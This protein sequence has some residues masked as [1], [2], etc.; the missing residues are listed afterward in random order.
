MSATFIYPTVK[1]VTSGFIGNR[2]HHG[3]DFAEPGYHEIKAVAA[4]KVSRSYLST[5]YGEVVFIVHSIYGT[6]YESVYAHMRTGSRRVRVGDKVKQGQVIGI[7]GNTGRSTGQHLH[8]ELHKGRWNINKTNAVNPLNYL[9]KDLNPKDI[10][11]PVKKPT[12]SSVI[13]SIQK[14]LN[15]RYI[16]RLSVDGIA[17]SATK[18]ALVKAYQIELNS[19]FNKGLVVDGI[20]GPRTRNAAVILREGARNNLIYIL[21]A[22]LYIKGYSPGNLD[23]I[24]GKKTTSAIKAFQRAKG[25]KADGIVGKQTTEKL[26]KG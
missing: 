3:I 23:G 1:R 21:Q 24:I 2:N 16:F 22:A 7:M 10:N 15:D 13:K 19:Q 17:G 5:S 11:S 8:F 14:T 4:G 25:L 12:N 9:G 20:W 18:K 26:L 6:T